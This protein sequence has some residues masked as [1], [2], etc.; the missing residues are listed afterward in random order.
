MKNVYMNPDYTVRE[1]L[2]EEAT[3]IAKWYNEEFASHC[4]EVPDE[5]MPN[6]EYDPN[7]KQW[8]EPGQR[9]PIEAPSLLKEAINQI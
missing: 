3:P 1:V 8:F 9:G 7:T 2:P 4:M 6:W 5:V